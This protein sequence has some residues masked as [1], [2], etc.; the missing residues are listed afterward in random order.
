LLE[1]YWDAYE[2]VELNMY[3][4]YDYLTEVWGYHEGIADAIVQGEVDK[5]KALNE[6]HL[7][8][9]RTRGVVH[10]K[11]RGEVLEEGNTQVRSP[12]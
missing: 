11:A 2:A 5:A 1:A 3:A 9:L 12:A 6:E 8:L 7:K 4:D 10:G